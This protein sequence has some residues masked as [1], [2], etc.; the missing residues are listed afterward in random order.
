M[1]RRP[2][3]TVPAGRRGPADRAVE[4]SAGGGTAGGLGGIGASGPIRPTAIRAGEGLGR[5]P[6][7]CRCRAGLA[8]PARPLPRHPPLV[9]RPYLTLRV[10]EWNTLRP[11]GGGSDDRPRGP[12]RATGRPAGRCPHRPPVRSY[13]CWPPWRSYRRCGWRWPGTPY[14]RGPRTGPAATAAARRSAWTG[15]CRRSGPRPAA[16]P[17]GPGSGRPRARSSWPWSR[18]WRCSCWPAARPA[19]WPRLAWWL[20]WAVP[21]ALVDA[22]VHRLPDRLSLPGGGRHLGAARAWPR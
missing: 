3:A 14:H 1:T 2:G 6:I 21:L 15:R 20:A 7:G 8:R 4:P 11:S 10:P 19:S 17:A 5:A 22:A 12:D 13:A 18:R 9:D 16:R